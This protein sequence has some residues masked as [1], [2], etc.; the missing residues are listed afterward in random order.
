[1]N[2]WIYHC[3]CWVIS[4]VAWQALRP[5]IHHR[6]QRQETPISSLVDKTEQ[7]WGK[8]VKSN[9]CR[10]LNIGIYP[11]LL[12][13]HHMARIVVV[14]GRARWLGM[15]QSY[16]KKTQWSSSPSASACPFLQKTRPAAR[17]HK[18]LGTGLDGGTH[19]WVTRNGA[20]PVPH[21]EMTRES[22]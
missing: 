8:P 5:L 14:H 1:M 10:F 15:A 17:R 13:N 2:K 22:S 11:L 21:P 4:P 3:P 7:W 20:D 12:R 16:H 18:A 9:K 6:F 19:G